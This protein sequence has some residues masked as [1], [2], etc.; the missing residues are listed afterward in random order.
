MDSG[1][2]KLWIPKQDD[3]RVIEKL[4]LLGTGKLDLGAIKRLAQQEKAG[5]LA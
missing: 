1:L 3:I 4:P 5:A 2:P